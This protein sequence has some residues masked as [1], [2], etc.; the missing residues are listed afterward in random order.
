MMLAMQITLKYNPGISYHNET[1]C[2]LSTS[3]D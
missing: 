3:N 1:Q 2:E